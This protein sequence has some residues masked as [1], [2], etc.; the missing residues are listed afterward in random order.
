MSFAVNITEKKEGVFE[1]FPNGPID[2]VTYDIFKNK[3]DSILRSSAKVAIINM[4]EVTHISSLGLGVL[5][6]L[7]ESVEKNDGVFMMTNLR[8][9]IK[10]VFD[11]M[12]ALKGMNVFESTEEADAYLDKIQREN[13]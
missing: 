2:S 1:V 10:K 11:I 8:P 6:R 13:S 12:N 9:R 4:D 7:K 3:T 5:I